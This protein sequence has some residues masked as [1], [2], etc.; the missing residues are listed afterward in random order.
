MDF[1]VGQTP[2]DINLKIEHVE[3]T[4]EAEEAAAEEEAAV[5]PGFLYNV[6]CHMSIK[7]VYAEPVPIAA[8]AVETVTI[9]GKE[10]KDGD[11]G[12]NGL[13]SYSYS[14]SKSND[15]EEV[16]EVVTE[17]TDKCNVEITGGLQLYKLT[18]ADKTRFTDMVSRHASRA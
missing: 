4:M 5:E 14:N 11:D 16:V 2:V 7:T 13:P 6:C 12:D 8:E 17:N 9:A 15:S 10:K 3:R 18:D 1:R